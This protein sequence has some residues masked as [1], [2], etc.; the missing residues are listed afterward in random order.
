MP[1]PLIIPAAM[2]AASTLY[3]AGT[4]IGQMVKANKLSKTPRPDYQ[5]PQEQIQALENA[6]M[7][8]AQ[9]RLPGQG[10][11]EQ[12]MDRAMANSL[13]SVSQTATSGA[14]LSQA[15]TSLGLDR[16]GAARDLGIKAAEN[17]QQNQIRLADELK[18]MAAQRVKKWEW[19]KGQPYMNAMQSAAQLRAAGQQNIGNAISSAAGGAMGLGEATGFTEGWLK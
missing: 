14:Q 13:Q 17:K 18:S 11:I 10:L 8:A 9:N 6:R 16:M 5:I 15:A 12:N 3:Q 19:E 7:M 2:M 4:G 1:I